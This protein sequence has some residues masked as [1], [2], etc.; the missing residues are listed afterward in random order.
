[1]R[2]YER[3][4]KE[5]IFQ[6]RSKVK[7]IKNPFDS[8]IKIMAP[9]GEFQFGTK[10]CF[11]VANTEKITDRYIVGKDEFIETYQEAAE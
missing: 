7:A 11:I 1:M 4:E 9:W 2:L 6:S 5:G 3:T 10:D 8:D